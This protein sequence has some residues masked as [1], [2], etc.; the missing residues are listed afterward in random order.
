MGHKVNITASDPGSL[1]ANKGSEQGGN[2]TP[3][4]E[5]TFLM[6]TLRTLEA[7]AG[8]EPPSSEASLVTIFA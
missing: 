8:A 2:D 5:I 3:Q 1:E 6:L 7:H 4:D